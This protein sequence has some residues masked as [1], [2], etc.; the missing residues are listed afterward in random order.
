MTTYLIIG[1]GAAGN[2]AAAAIRKYDQEGAIH[3][4]SKGKYPFYYVPAL[5]EYLAGEKQ[6]S[7]FTLNNFSWYV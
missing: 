4:F 1:N 2:A 5:P 7:Q 3:L 6:L